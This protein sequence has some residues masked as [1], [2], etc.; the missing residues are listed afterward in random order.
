MK[1]AAPGKVVISGAYAVLEGAPAIVSAV[2]R[3][4]I[5]DSRLGAERATPEVRAAIGD[6]RPPWVDASALFSGGQKL[7]LGASAAIL[8]AS[9][10]AIEL[11]AGG[12]VDDEALCKLIFARALAAHARAQGGGSGIDVAAS[13]HG[14]TLLVRRSGEGLSLER[15]RL[16]ALH[17]EVWSSQSPASTPDLIARVR[18]L[19][20]REPMAAQA[21]AAHEAADA[22]QHSDAAGLI[23]A[24]S[25]QL[26][27]LDALGRAAAAPIVT[28]PVRELARLAR[29]ADSIVLPSGAGGGDV[30]L[31]VGPTGPPAELLERALELDHEK[32]ELA[33][34]ARGVHALP[35]SGIAGPHHD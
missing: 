9:L 26:D 16:P 32:L 35:A 24:L 21:R 31:F 6:A 33:L 23:R 3:Y 25:A 13:A 7:G 20:G 2:S 5:A 27:A 30:A 17:V 15:V 1:A 18:A 11:E 8:V 19:S 29:A 22:L 14:G 10:A 28:G 4:A 12:V 34:G